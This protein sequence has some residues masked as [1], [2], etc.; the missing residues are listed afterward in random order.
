M[1]EAPQ[2]LLKILVDQR[3]WRYVDFERHFRRSATEL[4]DAGA[5]NL[6]VSESQY[7][8]WTAG[9]VQTLPGP[10]ACR[11]LEYMFGID[12]ATL[13]GP[14][15][16]DLPAPAFNLEDEIDMTARDAQSEAGAAAAASISDIALDQLRDDVATLAREYVTTP[17]YVVFQKAKEMRESAEANRERTQVP[18]Q[19]QELLI[20][21]GQACALLATAAFD[22]GSLDGARR[23]SRSAALYGEAARFDP[24]RAFAGGTLAYIAYFSGRPAE[25]VRVAR[26]ARAFTGLGDV[27][28]RRLAAIEARAFGH[29]GDIASAQRALD[30][31]TA[32]GSGRRDDLHDEVGG[33]FGFSPERLAMS[34]ASTCLLIGDGDRA[35][36]IAVQA[37]DLARS[38]PSA[39]RSVRVVGGAGADLA[40]ARLLRDDLDGA[41]QALEAMWLVPKEQRA[42][43]LLARAARVRSGLSSSRYSQ[44]VLA[45]ELGERIEDF[46]RQSAPRQLGAGPLAIEG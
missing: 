37:L 39:T 15:P 35:E 32:D 44:A 1:R 14:P 46:T 7:R 28:R 11:V 18:A 21:A 16:S 8:R 17:T 45:A 19:Q 12:V 26:A 41:A 10:D 31:S 42:T 20:V 3:R 38:R 5:R 40:A 30:A 4:L 34:N 6:T 13:F 25:G 27:A 43:G 24:L 33:E 29:L 22:L 2:T 9:R 36:R 23:L